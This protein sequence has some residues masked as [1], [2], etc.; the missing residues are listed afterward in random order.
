MNTLQTR[1]PRP[2]QMA[3]ILACCAGFAAPPILADTKTSKDGAKDYA[4]TVYGGR[5]T[6]GDWHESFGPGTNFIDSDLV[7][8]A[9]AKTL[10]RSAD[11]GRSY[12]VEAQIAKHSG[13]QDNLEYNLLGAVRW[14]DLF[15]SEKLNTTAAIGLGASYASS[16][17]RAEATIINSGSEK[18]L[19]Y[20]HLELTLG[21]PRGD[22][23]A[24]LRMHHRS[25]AYGL[26]GGNGGSNAVT[27]GVRYEFD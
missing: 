3:G 8:A 13:I 21:P 2:K 10:S 5:L 17:P 1:I 18:L 24:S 7:V 14:H 19:A 23:Q 20:W 4:L 6:D 27:L 15:W 9:L 26:F 25:T 12:E 22:W 11:G 16:V